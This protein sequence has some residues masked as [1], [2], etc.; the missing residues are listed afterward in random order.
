MDAHLG[1]PAGASP[2]AS[3]GIA[4]LDRAAWGF[5]P[6]DLWL[7]AGDP[8]QGV[9]MLLTQWA[10]HL[11][12]HDLRVWL[13][14]PVASPLAVSSRLLAHGAH[15]ALDDVRRDW[16]PAESRERLVEARHRIAGLPLRVFA[17][18][19]LRDPA[20]L[21]RACRGDQGPD[22]LLVD[23]QAATAWTPE[24]L[25]MVADAGLVTVAGVEVAEVAV[26]LET[27]AVTP[28]SR[29]ADRALVVRTSGITRAGVP[30]EDGCGELS[31]VR[32]R[33]GPLY[34]CPVYFDGCYSRFRDHHG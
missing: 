20:A 10:L 29:A 13:L 22:V 3:T 23:D 26:F 34:D 30:L 21:L 2:I 24:A 25:R 18:R 5:L 15:M 19:A 6:G 4:A 12:S 32:N 1:D 33:F 11:A 9:S 8:G 7:V 17:Q 14:A 28:L 27:G 31:L 16:V